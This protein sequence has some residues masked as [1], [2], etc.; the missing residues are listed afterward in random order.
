[1]LAQQMFVKY[2]AKFHENPTYCLAVNIRSGTDIRC[3][4]H[5]RSS[6]LLYKEC[7][8]MTNTKVY[9]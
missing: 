8:K 7:F 1:M 9:K 3:G 2:Y 6:L 4:H 5:I